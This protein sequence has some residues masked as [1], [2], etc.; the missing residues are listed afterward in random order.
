M[1]SIQKFHIMI[2]IDIYGETTDLENVQQ[3]CLNLQI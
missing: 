1:T 2:N 3:V